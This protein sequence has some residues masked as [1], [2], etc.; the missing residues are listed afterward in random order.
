M[1]IFFTLLLLTNI[2]F[3][4][5]QWLI[6][7][8]QITAQSKPL[9]T[10]E[11][12]QLVSEIESPFNA[13]P[14]PTPA[15]IPVSVAEPVIEPEPV[16]SESKPVLPIKLCY[17]LGPFKGKPAAQKVIQAFRKNKLGI[18][19]RASQE[20]EYMGQMVYLDGNSTRKQAIEKA[21]ALGRRGVRD[22]IIV[23][24]GNHI[25]ILSLGVFSLKVNAER[26]LNNIAKLGYQVKSEARY[27]NR[28]IYWL[29]YS[30]TESE[31]LSQLIDDLKLQNGISKISRQCR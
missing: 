26:R 5:V 31:D 10:A 3:A 18:D 16:I 9:Q 21:E 24:E 11:R 1:K 14:A 20:K 29:D 12:L 22:Y 17:T 30:E 15:S 7:F 4:L 6:P 25:N 19:L 2:A 8:E 27:R 13:K 23:N 28:T